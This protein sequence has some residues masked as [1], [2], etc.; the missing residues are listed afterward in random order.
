MLNKGRHEHAH[1]EG[2]SSTT[3]GV[4]ALSAAAAV[5]DLTIYYLSYSERPIKTHAMLIAITLQSASWLYA[6]LHLVAELMTNY[7]SWNC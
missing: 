1:F 2:S 4:L 7:F 3:A 6:N 5:T